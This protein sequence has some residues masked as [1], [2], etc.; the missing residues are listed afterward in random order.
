MYSVPPG[1]HIGFRVWPGICVLKKV[2]KTMNSMHSEMIGALEIIWLADF[3][4]GGPD[5]K[6]F[7]SVAIWFLWQLLNSAVVAQKLP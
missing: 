6:Y 1:V 2:N 7:G 5:C 4:C 3:F